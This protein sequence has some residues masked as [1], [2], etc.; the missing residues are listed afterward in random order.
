[1]S[2]ATAG[3]PADAMPAVECKRILKRGVQLRVFVKV[4]WAGHGGNQEVEAEVF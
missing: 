2:S 4:S 3:G 1:M